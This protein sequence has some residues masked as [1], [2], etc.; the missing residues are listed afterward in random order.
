MVSGGRGI[1]A[2]SRVAQ[3]AHPLAGVGL[4]VADAS[5]NRQLAIEAARCLST[6]EHQ[7]DFMLSYGWPSG[8][9]TGLRRL[10]D[11]PCLSHG[12]PAPDEPAACPPR[13]ETS[14][15]WEVSSALQEVLWP[16]DQVDPQSTPQAAQRAVDAA[17][18]VAIG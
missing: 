15:Y 6:H 4:A 9:A 5:E 7:I 12:R 8:L 2:P 11:S 3:L 13:P 16:P 10:E 14:N 17:L 18:C 1:R